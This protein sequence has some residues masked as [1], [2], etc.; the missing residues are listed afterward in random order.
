MISNPD[1]LCHKVFKA[2]FFPNCSILE[3][4][5]VNGGSYA[6]KSIC[7]DRDV[8]KRGMVWR[9]G[10][11]AFVSIKE[12]KWLLDQ[13]YRTI[14]SPLP[15]IP[16]NAKVN[17]LIDSTSCAWKSDVVHQNFLPHEAK[18]ILSIPLSFR[19]P[20]DRLI[21]SKTPS[22]LLIARS[23][24]K[25]LACDASA[26]NTSN[27]NPNPQKSFWRGLWMLQILSKMKHFAW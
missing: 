15:N 21:W 20:S 2:R 13:C 9:I 18:I 6:W 3:A 14:I 17:S 24:Y 23:A 26:N 12:D 25:L 4:P 16:P 10:N 7:S 11:G 19:L 27:S 8:V 5:E 1:S 22:S